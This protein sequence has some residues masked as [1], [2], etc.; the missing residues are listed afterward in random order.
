[1]A[2]ILPHPTNLNITF[3]IVEAKCLS[4]N[5]TEYALKDKK[6]IDSNSFE[7]EFKVQ[8]MVFPDQK[9]IT[10]DFNT[11]LF[12][13]QSTSKMAL[14]ELKAKITFRIE[15]FAEIIKQDGQI[16][17]IPHPLFTLTANI[18]VSAVRG[19]FIVKLQD[20]HL[21]NAILPPINPAIFI[22]PQ[23]PAAS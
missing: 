23:A 2:T 1:M 15:N 6:V 12:E 10:V 9:W 17:N 20:S 8:H 4:F 19:M 11:T 14:A 13:I 21:S 16:M 3:S 18:V 22:P 7:F 5:F